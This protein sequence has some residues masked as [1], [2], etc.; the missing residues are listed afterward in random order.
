MEAT[1]Q[2]FGKQGFRKTTTAQVAERAGVSVGSLY[3][4]F[5]DKKA[6]IA[7]F[8]E[9]RLEEDVE[10]MKRVAAR[11]QGASPRDVL[12][13]VTEEMVELYR[14]D[15]ELYVSVVE[16]LPIME[17]TRE[18]REGLERAVSLTAMHLRASPELHGER[19]PDLLARIIVHA[20]RSSLF[21]IVENDPAKL[22]DPHLKA[23]LVGGVEGF[24]GT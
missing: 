11:A 1:G 8:F 10:L 7:S 21:R 24:L 20:L 23:I 5:P 15:R 6:L 16:I 18:V 14:R 9:K 22:D 4:Y 2:V 19:D 17:Q 12:R 13:F 3:Q